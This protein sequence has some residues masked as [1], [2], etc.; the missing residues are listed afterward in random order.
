M[1]KCVKNIKL[2]LNFIE[3]FSH[4]THGKNTRGN[5]NLLRVPKVRTENGR[6]SFKFQG[7]VCFNELPSHIRGEVSYVRFMQKCRDHFYA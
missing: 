1:F 6:K 4:V 2:P 7:V 3:Y 5:N